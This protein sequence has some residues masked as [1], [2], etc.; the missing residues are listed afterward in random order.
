MRLTISDFIIWSGVVIGVG[1]WVLDLIYA[2]SSDFASPG[3]GKAALTFVLLQPI[4]YIF[5]FM[6][7]IGSHEHIEDSAERKAKMMIAFPY[8]FLAQ[9]RLLG[10]HDGAN[11]YIYDQ[12]PRKDEFVFFNM[13]NSYRI[14]TV[15]EI[16][17]QCFP[18]MVIQ[19][20]N[21]N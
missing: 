21:N 7:Y 13:E 12:F 2:V 14:Q 18:Q 15:V 6:V 20:K 1:D 8:A 16:A 11:A 19:A 4:W 17:L 10:A 9:F 5:M 3:I